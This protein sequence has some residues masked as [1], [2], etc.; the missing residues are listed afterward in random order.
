MKNKIFALVLLMIT[1]LGCNSTKKNTESNKL[2]QNAIVGEKWTL[3]KLEGREVPQQDKSVY[4]M[5]NPEYKK[6]NGFSGC[7][8]MM[9]TYSLKHGNQIRFTKIATTRMAC[10]KTDIDEAKV[11]KIF[12]IT[13]NYTITGDTLRLHIGRRATLA[14][15]IKNT[16]QITE[17]HWK[18]VELEGQ[19]VKMVENQE[20][21]VY[22]RLKTEEN[23][24]QGFA[25]CNSFNGTYSIE[26]ENRIRFSQMAATLKV[27]PNVDINETEFL[28][29]FQT[30]DNYTVNEDTLR[31][32]VGKR[33]SL[34]VFEAVY[35]E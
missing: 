33:A 13:D 11:L 4:F 6:L 31:L 27:C 20:K 15:F 19:P 22:F 34:A 24:V 2:N 8:N 30:A 28:K 29:V 18:L 7:N 26:K 9:G 25:G 12:E 10:P 35:F 1:A 14:V 32:N 23:R 17:K 21:E 5:L 16:P 3:I